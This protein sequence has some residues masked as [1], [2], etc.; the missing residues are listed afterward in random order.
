MKKSILAL[1]LMTI[2]LAHGA[3]LTPNAKVV[4]PGPAGI[5]FSTFSFPTLLV[6]DKEVQLS[7]EE[8]GLI[9]LSE[10]VSD[11]D[12]DPVSNALAKHLGK[13]VA[14]IQAAAIEHYQNR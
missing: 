8:A 7:S 14:E 3:V 4:P 5:L 10:A 11:S 6:M 13:D 2:G 9:I 1:I 12:N